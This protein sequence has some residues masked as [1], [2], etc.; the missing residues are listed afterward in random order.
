VR[1]VVAVDPQA[2]YDPENPKSETGIIVAGVDRAKHYHVLADLSGNYLPDE[3]A[4]RV[5]HAFDDSEADRVVIEVNQGGK[6]VAHTLRTIRPNLPIQEVRATRGKQ[7]RAEPVAAL[8]E[9]GKVHHL[10]LFPHLEEQMTTWVPEM[11]PDSPDRVDALTYAIQ[12][13]AF[14]GTARVGWT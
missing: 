13:L 11:T 6:M 12:A 4:R 14:T 1:V 9:Q 7:V 10:G 5:V 8:Y 3:W 2:S